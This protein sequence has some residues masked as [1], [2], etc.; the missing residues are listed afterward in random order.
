MSPSDGAAGLGE[1][2]P[3]SGPA[4]ASG[5]YGSL[6]SCHQQ[7]SQRWPQISLPS[8]V[9]IESWSSV[10]VSAGRLQKV[11]GFHPLP[12]PCEGCVRGVRSNHVS[13]TERA[14]RHPQLGGC[15]VPSTFLH[16]SLKHPAL[17]EMGERRPD[18]HGTSFSWTPLL[19]TPCSS[20]RLSGW[21][22]AK[23]RALL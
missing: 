6:A 22:P 9:E 2:G 8:C 19:S 12:E 14:M 1:S 20:P 18:G 11:S 13:G 3:D 10:M 5:C 15:F 4:L 23:R 16:A 7:C 21:V 17:M